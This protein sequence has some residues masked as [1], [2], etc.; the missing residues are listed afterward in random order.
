MLSVLAFIKLSRLKSFSMKTKDAIKLAGSTA[1]L[2]EILDISSSAISQWGSSIPKA[3]V[4]QLQV[5]K[6]EWFTDS[7]AAKQKVK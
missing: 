7:K 6:P 2:A 4:W 1:K 3:R 5:L